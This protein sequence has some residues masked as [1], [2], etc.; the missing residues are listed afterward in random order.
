MIRSR[1]ASWKQSVLKNQNISLRLSLASALAFT[2][3]QDER[4]LY[5]VAEEER[6]KNGEGLECKKIKKEE[7]EKKRGMKRDYNLN[8]DVNI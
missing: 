6:W 5:A 2:A 7:K 8:G 3:W 1:D 4:D